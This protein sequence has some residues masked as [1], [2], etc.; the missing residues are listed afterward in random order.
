MKHHITSK[1]VRLLSILFLGVT[2]LLLLSVSA[3]AGEFG[4]TFNQRLT[5]KMSSWHEGKIVGINRWFITV[6]VSKDLLRH[7]KTK[8]FRTKDYGYKDLK[9]GD[10]VLINFHKEHPSP[11]TPNCAG[12]L[13][14]APPLVGRIDSKTKD[15]QSYTGWGYSSS[16]LTWFYRTGRWDARVLFVSGKSK[17]SGYS[18]KLPN[19]KQYTIRDKFDPKSP[20]QNPNAETRK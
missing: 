4:A 12:S 16:I 19:G 20:I 7:T 17:F 9:K 3:N 6:D 18:A 14:N 10:I 15:V 1:L 2:A 11:V 5:C 8:R 13:I